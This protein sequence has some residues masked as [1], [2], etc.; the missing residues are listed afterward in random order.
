MALTDSVVLCNLMRRLLRVSASSTGALALPATDAAAAASPA[1]SLDAVIEVASALGAPRWFSGK[2]LLSGNIRLQLAFVATVF[3]AC[4]NMPDPEAP[5]T[6]GLASVG[7]GARD[8]SGTANS[9]VSD[10][11]VALSKVHVSAHASALRSALQAR[12][13]TEDRDGDRQSL[14]REARTVA[15]WVNTLDIE[16]VML[17]GQAIAQE[18]RDGV[19]LLK[20]L[21]VVEPGI[22]KWSKVNVRPTNRYKMVR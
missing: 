9:V 21:D 15:Q 4:P 19:G 13:A 2:G 8:R 3:K 7:S 14:G 12:F 22:V 18:L 16:G 5:P 1:A 10:T 11:P 20:L 17:H 6:V